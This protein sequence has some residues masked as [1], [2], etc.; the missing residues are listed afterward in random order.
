MTEANIS[1]PVVVVI[2]ECAGINMM[3]DIFI[4]E[5]DKIFCEAMDAGVPVDENKAGDLAYSR[6]RDRFADMC[7]EAKDR[8]K[9][10]D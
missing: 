2:R 8:E 9:Y 7:D 3:K 10:K 1:L 5:Y 6:M 4:E